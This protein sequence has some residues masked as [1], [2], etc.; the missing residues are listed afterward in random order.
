MKN[1]KYQKIALLMLLAAIICFV[2]SGY[3]IVQ[4]IINPQIPDR[5]KKE[6]V[7]QTTTNNVSLKDENL[8]DTHETTTKES[9]IRLA[10][11]KNVEPKVV[12]NIPVKTNQTVDVL[13][14]PENNNEESKTT[15]FNGVTLS[16]SDIL[17]LERTT[18][19]EAGIC[20]EAT[21][22]A[23]AAT[24]LE[25]AAERNQTIEEVI[26]EPGQFSC[27]I[28]G[29][30]YL[31]T[32]KGNILTTPKMAEKVS[33]TV[34]DAIANGSGISDLLGGEPL[35]FYSGDGLDSIEAEKRST[36]SVSVTL[37]RVTFYR[38]WD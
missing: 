16:Q 11:T 13:Q 37:D 27:A 23:V 29:E 17:L 28:D 36:I 12:A 34:Y 8:E 20:N 15:A 10:T 3:W 4:A 18:Y 24:I 33:D 19:A 21:Q 35:F 9:E 26:F 32:V 31:V 6:E 1:R 7:V 2:I 25:R 38:V 22:R 5:L 14:E 30:I